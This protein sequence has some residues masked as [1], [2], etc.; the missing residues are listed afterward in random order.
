M[1]IWLFEVDT[2]LL[3]FLVFFYLMIV[4]ITGHLRALFAY[5][6]CQYLRFCELYILSALLKTAVRNC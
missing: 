2:T 1:R 5:E 6:I 3:S 4:I